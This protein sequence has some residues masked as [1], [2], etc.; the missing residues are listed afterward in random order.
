MVLAMFY[1]PK[2]MRSVRRI[3]CTRIAWVFG[4]AGNEMLEKA[5]YESELRNGRSPDTRGLTRIGLP[6][7]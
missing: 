1:D 6:S 2:V 5:E 4:L 7:V 3:V